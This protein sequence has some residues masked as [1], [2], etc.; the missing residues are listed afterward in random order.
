[1][2]YTI[3]A[4]GNA[5]INLAPETLIEEILQNITMILLTTK[6]TAP[7]DRNFGLS[8]RFLDRR[9]PVAESILV[10]EIYD[11]IEQYEPRVEIVSV[12]FERDE[13]NGRITP[14]LEVE[15]NGG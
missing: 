11:A 4:D 2:A 3:T 10:A 9:T 6:Y 8:A 15:I 13:R 14:R 1:M 12:N 5:I 7:L